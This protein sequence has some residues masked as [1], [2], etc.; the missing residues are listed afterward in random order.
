MMII[1]DMRALLATA[2]DAPFQ[3]VDLAR[4]TPGPGQV[5]VRIR[6]SGVNPLD[7][8]IRAGEAAHARHPLPSILGLDMA[9]TV[10]A[11]G[12]GVTGFRYGDEVFGMVGGVGGH[13]GTLAQ[14]VAADA[15]LLALRPTN[16]SFREAA[17]LPLIF[18]TA[19]EGLID[20]AHVQLGEKVLVLGGAG[21]VGHM[22]VQLAKAKGAEV[23]ATDRDSP[24]EAYVGKFTDGEGF[25]IVY[26]TVGGASLDTAFRAVKSYTGRVVS[27]LGWGSHALA[28]LSFRAA[29]YSGVFT[30]L[31]LLSGKG[32]AHHGAI[33]REGAALAEN[34]Q[35]LPRLDPTRFAL[36][37][38]DAA[39][40]A[41][42][43]RRTQGKVVVEID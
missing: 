36:A 35:L 30:L 37:D 1:R 13:Q 21:G 27:C 33:L 25:D 39:H 7:L 26:D 40:D 17:A 10:E 23:Y 32:R 38:A 16:L 9:G 43:Q 14:Y 5:L 3:T 4:P 18:I 28:P 20:R 12:A 6:A 24:V 2:P 19:W 41:L 11:V 34:G 8:K 15:D 22:V 42:R 31:P 29:T